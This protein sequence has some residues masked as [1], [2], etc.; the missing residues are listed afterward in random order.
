MRE[1]AAIKAN[2]GG[3][4]AEAFTWEDAESFVITKSL[5]QSFSLRKSYS[6]RSRAGTTGIQVCHILSPTSWPK[7]T[8][9]WPCHFSWLPPRAEISGLNA[10]SSLLL[11][12]HNFFLRWWCR[13][14]VKTSLGLQSSSPSPF[15][16]RLWVSEIIPSLWCYTENSNI[17][18]LLPCGD[19]TKKIP[20]NTP[21]KTRLRMLILTRGNNSSAKI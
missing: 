15:L 7:I 2:F 19:N 9:F 4:G 5:F 14:A 11:A 16:R 6:Q 8:I 18:C 1:K 21:A 17:G 12:P 10:I 13:S 3:I 20:R